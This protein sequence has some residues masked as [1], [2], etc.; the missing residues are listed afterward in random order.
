MTELETKSLFVHTTMALEQRISFSATAF[1]TCA[2]IAAGAVYFVREKKRASSPCMSPKDLHK[3]SHATGSEVVEIYS[4]RIKNKTVVVTGA[5]SGLGKHTALLLA[6]K[7]AHVILGVRNVEAGEQV[8]NEI[9][10]NGGTAEVWHLDLMSLDSVRDFSKKA[11]EK[12]VRLDGLINNAGVYGVKGK[13]PDGYQTTWQ[14][15]VLAHA[16]LTELLLPQ[17][18]E[19]ARIVHVSSEIER[20]VRNIAKNCPPETDGSG[21]YDYALSKACQVLHAHALTLRFVKEK[22]NRRAFAVE[23]GLV[24]T[25]IARHAGLVTQWVN[26]RLLG[27]IFLRSVNQG[28]AS[29]LFCLL[30]SFEDLRKDERG[31]PYYYYANCAPRR[32]TKCCSNETE[33]EAQSKLF[34]KLLNL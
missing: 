25:N 8:R 34:A 14:T 21:T 28:C 27:P 24:K 3:N 4:D 13:T 12:R 1:L 2:A 15:N 32:P 10:K 18:S 29:T 33:A 22:S 11:L 30:A 31:N 23:P 6:T 7:G 9:I 20:L 5:S 19:D 16:L 26:Y 17:M